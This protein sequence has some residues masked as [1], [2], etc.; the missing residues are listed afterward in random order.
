MRKSK[1]CSTWLSKA[2]LALGGGCLLFSSTTTEFQT[3]KR[4]WLPISYSFLQVREPF[5]LQFSN[6]KIQPQHTTHRESLSQGLVL[7]AILWKSPHEKQLFRLNDTWLNWA[8]V[9]S[10]YC[11]FLDSCHLACPMTFL[12]YHRAHIDTLPTPEKCFL[13]A[14]H[15]NILMQSP[16]NSVTCNH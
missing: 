15:I 8:I 14:W 1:M 2:S 11:L 6:Y 3:P 16:N 13:V 4:P 12:V 5:K 7:W 9:P 10:E